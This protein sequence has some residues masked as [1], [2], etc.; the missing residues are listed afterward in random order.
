MPKNLSQ[1]LKNQQTPIDDLVQLAE[2]LSGYPSED[3][4][5]MSELATDTRPI[6]TKL[7]LD[8]G[9]TTAGE[10]YHA[11]LIEY[12]KASSDFS[13]QIGQKTADST[14][15]RLKRVVEVITHG[16]A[17]RQVWALKKNVAKQ[18]LKTHQP[19]KLMALLHYRSLDSMLK[20]ENVG[21]IYGALSYT[22]SPR[23]LKLMQKS[24]SSL[25]S[26]DFET[27][28]AEFILAPTGHWS[29]VAA[30]TYPI[31][32]SSEL[33]A[34]I[35]WP[36]PKA[37]QT[38]SLG[39]SVLGLQAA[40]ELRCDS[41][42]LKLHQFNHN[43]GKLISDNFASG[44][45]PRLK[46]SGGHTVTWRAIQRVFAGRPDADF[47]ENFEPH[48]EKLDLNRQTPSEILSELAPQLNFWTN[49][50]SV[51]F[52]DADGHVVSCNL[53]DTAA[54]HA[55]KKSLSKHNRSFAKQRLEDKL[56]GRYLNH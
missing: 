31:S 19:K 7:N 32:K 24:L 46:I 23:W 22:E 5:L 4:R 47:S 35:F 50:E 6:L 42:W 15:Q 48:L 43:L 41:S 55:S 45:G 53:T 8:P 9:D 49:C 1:L 20:R 54:N 52:C 13:R 56:V 39:L 26:K 38:T 17:N 10:L 29:A 37:N 12:E 16:Q 18:L 14:T 28:E 27:R 11:L 34:V 40:D 25:S 44:L 51:L 3:I 30:K 2:E 33:G 21:L 36:N